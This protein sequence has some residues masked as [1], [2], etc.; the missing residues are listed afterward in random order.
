MPPYKRVHKDSQG[1]ILEVGQK[2]AYNRS[3]DVVPGEITFLGSEIRILCLGKNTYSYSQQVQA[4]KP[5]V[6]RVRNGTSVLVL[7]DAPD[8][9]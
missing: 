8:E 3:G 2:V 6:S 1:R 5:I 4:G 9:P 7:E